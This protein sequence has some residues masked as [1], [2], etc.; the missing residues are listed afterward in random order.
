MSEKIFRHS[1]HRAADALK[2]IV[3]NKTNATIRDLEETEEDIQELEGIVISID[4]DKITGDGW[5]VQTD[6]G[7]TYKCSCA[8]S[9]YELPETNE[10]GGVYY[11]TETVK[12][13][14][15]INPVLRTNRIVE[16]TS[17]DLEAA[18]REAEQSAAKTTTENEDDTESETETED[19]SSTPKLDLSK[20]KHGDKA[21]TI[22]AKPM[23]AISVSD[24]L[25]S[26]NYNNDNSVTA[27]GESIATNGKKTSILTD[28]LEIGSENVTW[29]G[30][31]FYDM[32]KD[33]A[34]KILEENGEPDQMQIDSGINAIMKEGFGQLF[35]NKNSLDM[36]KN[37]ERI[38]AD[39]INPAMF[40][41][42]PQKHPLLSGSNIDELYIYPNGLVTVRNT[43]ENWT[44]NDVFTTIN[45]L[46]PQY[47][48]KNVLRVTISQM[49]PCCYQNISEVQ[50][51]FNYCPYCKTW[52]TLSDNKGKIICDACNR[53]WCEACGHPH[54]EECSYNEKNLKRYNEFN[55]QG[56]GTYCDYCRDKIFEGRVREYANYCP[57]CHQW[58]YLRLDS[59]FLQKGECRVFIC[60]N[61][62][63][64]YC[65]N[66]STSL[67]IGKIDSFLDDRVYY[68]D[69]SV[70]SFYTDEVQTKKELLRIKHIRDE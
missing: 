44:K 30:K 23:S 56:L 35:I 27:D 47:T 19:T 16:M 48:R 13:K 61:C 15:E 28:D 55:I 17:A 66:C 40:P 21:T 65:V 26:F 31:D 3:G 49:C 4:K 38:I 46:A 50:E 52:N 41:E 18:K 29:Q 7:S 69:D 68:Y 64:E 25:I 54:G 12:V 33:E 37:N 59:T 39:L 63:E 57:K 34:L 5:E 22:I 24:A 62:H 8:T 11:P 58:G 1:P 53:T 32:L 36:Y 51:Y 2:I 43:L 6:D 10:Y 42:Y 70:K 67:K 45:W 60:D 9:M 14:I 20:W